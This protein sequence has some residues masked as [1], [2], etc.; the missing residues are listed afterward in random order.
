MEIS[1]SILRPREAEWKW[2]F[3]ESWRLWET[4]LSILFVE[5]CN[6]LKIDWYD[7]VGA[8]HGFILKVVENQ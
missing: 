5:Q 1:F 8:S 2:K 4:Q 3:G 6:I 7:I